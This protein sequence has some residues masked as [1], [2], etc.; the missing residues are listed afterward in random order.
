MDAKVPQLFDQARS[1]PRAAEQ[2]DSARP[3]ACRM[4]SPFIPDCRGG[5]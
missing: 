5:E 4:S 1:H 3:A 2:Q